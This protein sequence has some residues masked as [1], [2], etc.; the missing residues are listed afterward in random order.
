MPRRLKDTYPRI[1][2]LLLRKGV[3]KPADLDTA[4]ALQRQRLSQRRQAPK[5]G[6]ILVEQKIL[7]KKTVAEI[8]DEQRIGR[9]EK[10]HLDVGLRE[11]GGIA[12]VVLEG[13]LDETLQDQ[14]KKML[15]RL[16]DRG[17]AR[18]AI[19]CT[20]LVYLNSHGVSAFIAYIDEARARG[21]DLK[22]FGMNIDAKF[23]FDRLGLTQFVQ[24]F[25]GE[26]EAIHAFELPIDEYMSR[27]ALGEYVAV[28]GTRTFHLSYCAVI[29][30]V[31]EENKIYFES[32]KHARDSG[33]KPCTK[34]KP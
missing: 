28:V 8:L 19:D 22:F 25:N 27:G 10:R 26:P 3:V 5:L 15:E 2:E 17:Y 1:G 29:Q 14:L 33:R 16:M 20:K 6:E 24:I 23:T 34:C 9:G 4:L 12:V 30:K 31:H 21:G 13:R 18:I 7:D 11:S 32:K